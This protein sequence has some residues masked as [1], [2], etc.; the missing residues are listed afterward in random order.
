MPQDIQIAKAS[1]SRHEEKYPISFAQFAG[2]FNDLSSVLVPDPH[3]HG[4]GYLVRSVY[5]DDYY[6][7]SFFDK[8]DG[9]K[10]RAKLRLRIYSPDDTSVKLELKSK[11]ADAQRKDTIIISRSDA[12]RMLRGDYSF[13]AKYEGLEDLLLSNGIYMGGMHPVVLI[14][15]KRLAFMH[16]LNDIR[17]TLDSDIRENETK[18]DLFAESP[19][20]YPA[21]DYYESLLE[22][23]YNNFLP[24]YVADVLAKYELNRE[25]YG[26][27]NL[28]RRLL[29]GTIF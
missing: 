14:E 3:N 8:V 24:A 7:S 11:H 2:L 22:V 5:F 4:T 28:S 27:Y 29:E 23:K 26:K 15:Y 18:F 16:P 12:S 25:A 13:F 10:D 21:T 1:V 6:D 17:I 9:N 20:L 19:I